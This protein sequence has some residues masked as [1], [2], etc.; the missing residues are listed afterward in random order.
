[1][2]SLSASVF[3]CLSLLVAATQGRASQI[4]IK[5]GSSAQL[6]FVE[7]DIGG[8]RIEIGS[9][10]SG[11]S[12]K[13]TF[14]PVSDSSVQI[15]YRRPDTSIAFSCVGD[16]YVTTGLSQRIFANIDTNGTCHV[17]EK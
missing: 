6:T 2:S 11:Q 3:G 8:K 7:V 16:V 12:A 4:E 13:A 9:I 5:N 1:M 14:D 15:R 10:D 17:E